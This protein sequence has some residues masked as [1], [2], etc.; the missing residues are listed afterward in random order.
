M[1]LYKCSALLLHAAGSGKAVIA[2]QSEVSDRLS[3]VVPCRHCIYCHSYCVVS[4][5]FNVLGGWLK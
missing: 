3:F 1:N 5:F 4:L 2:R